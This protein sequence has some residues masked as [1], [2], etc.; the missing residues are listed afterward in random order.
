MGT[1]IKDHNAL[2]LLPSVLPHVVAPTLFA[3]AFFPA[4]RK[5][6]LAWLP[7]ALVPDADYFLARAF[8]RAAFHNVWIPLILTAAMI[9]VWRRQDPD[10]S[11]GEFAWRPGTP[12]N[13]LLA[14]YFLASH[15]FMDLFAGGISVL[16]PLTPRNFYFTFQIL[17]DT[18][19]NQPVTTI[20]GGTEPDIVTV[21]PKYE[22]WS[23][24][25]TA[26]ASFLAVAISAW[27]GYS[28]WRRLRSPPPITVHR[29]AVMAPIHKE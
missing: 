2:P 11:F 20:D 3:L 15:V 25:D 9:I 6:I 22:W 8:H 24:I 16:W 21:S 26:V 27:L 13:L 1:S 10:A 23:V 5:R 17:V 4:S 7:L 18:A 14:N 28:R 19:T 12:V 29:E